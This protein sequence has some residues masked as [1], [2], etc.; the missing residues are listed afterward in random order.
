MDELSA[1]W[2]APCSP[3]K[4][5]PPVL[6]VP[7]RFGHVPGTLTGSLY[8]FSPYFFFEKIGIAVVDLHR[9]FPFL[10]MNTFFK[11]I[12]SNL[13]VIL[14]MKGKYFQKEEPFHEHEAI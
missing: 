11:G 9:N 10:Q 7:S 1:S 12:K 3:Q 8:T 2:P 13:C 4:V 14:F 5:Q 6:M